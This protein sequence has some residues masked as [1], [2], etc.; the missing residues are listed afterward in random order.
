MAS[1]SDVLDGKPL[2][3]SSIDGKPLMDSSLD[4]KPKMR[5]IVID[6]DMQE[7]IIVAGQSIGL[8]LALT[9]S[10]DVKVNA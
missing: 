4:A 10:T 6:F 8:L 9:Y 1:N 3:D 2:M 5:D 7:R